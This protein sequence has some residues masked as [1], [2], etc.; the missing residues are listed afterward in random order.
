VPTLGSHDRAED[1]GKRGPDHPDEQAE[2]RERADGAH[3]DHLDEPGTL[4]AD[5]DPPPPDPTGQG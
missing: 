1:P 4:R 3:E 5:D 2:L